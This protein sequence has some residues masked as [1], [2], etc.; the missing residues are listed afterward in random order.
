MPPV[1]EHDTVRQFTKSNKTAGLERIQPPVESDVPESDVDQRTGDGVDPERAIDVHSARSRSSP[2]GASRDWS[3]GRAIA[4]WKAASCE[5]ACPIVRPRLRVALH[6]PARAARAPRCDRTGA[7]TWRLR[8]PE[9]VAAGTVC[10]PWRRRWPSSRG[11]RRDRRPPGGS[12]AARCG[13]G[14][15][16]SR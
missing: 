8:V 1:D 13:G 6:A 2:V 14:E 7:D 10:G 3:P 16:Q 5:L 9:P 4:R 11:V 15:H 12:R